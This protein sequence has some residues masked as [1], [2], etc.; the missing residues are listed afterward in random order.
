MGSWSCFC[1]ILRVLNI[2]RIQAC[3]KLGTLWIIQSGLPFHFLHKLFYV[4]TVFN[5]DEIQLINF[6][7]RVHSFSVPSKKSLHT[8]GLQRLP[9]MFPSRSFIILSSMVQSMVHFELICMWHEVRVLLF[10]FPCEY[11]VFMVLMVRL[12][13]PIEFLWHLLYFWIRF[14]SVGLHSSPYA[15]TMLSWLLFSEHSIALTM[16]QVWF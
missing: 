6:L 11:E 4:A 14:C 5:F 2:S 8:P 10:F 12:S 1:C 9:P 3:V 7:K 16:Y 15:N 13:F